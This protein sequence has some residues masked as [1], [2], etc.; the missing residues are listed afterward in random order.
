QPTLYAIGSFN[1]FRLLAKHM[2]ADQP[3]LG[4]SAPD[5]L[6]FQLPYRIEELARAYVRSIRSARHNGPICIAGFSA[7]GILAYEVA[8]ILAETGCKVDLLVLLD[9]PCPA[10]PAD[11]LL[12]RFAH[13]VRINLHNMMRAS[14]SRAG[15]ILQELSRRLWLRA[16]VRTLS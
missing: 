2:G 4:V 9:S 3:V 6:R 11:P 15:H 7:D 10:E 16:K 13:N 12:T 14:L 8:R 1:V 5:N